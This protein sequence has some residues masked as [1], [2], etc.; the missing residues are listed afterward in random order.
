MDDEEIYDEFG[1]LIGDELDSDVENSRSSQEILGDEKEYPDAKINGHQATQIVVA[2]EEEHEEQE[3]LEEKEENHDDDYDV[4]AGQEASFQSRALVKRRLSINDGEIIYVNPADATLDEQV[5]DPNIQKEMKTTIDEKELPQLTYSRE[6]LIDTINNV[7]ERIRNVA[8]VGSHQSGK[9]RFIDTFIKNTHI[10]PQDLESTKREAKS[11]RYL[12]NYKL[13]IERETTIKTSAITLM[14]Q[15]QRDRSFAIT[16]VDTPGHIDFQDEVVAGLQLCDGA[17]LVIDAVIGFTFRDKKLI[18]EIMKRDLPIIIVLNKIDNLILKLRLPPKDS[19]L[20]MYNILDDIN[21]YVKESLKRFNYSQ[22]IEFLPTL[23]NVIFASADYEISFSLQSFVALYAQTQ[24]HILEDA[25][26]A[27]FLWGEYFLDP[28]TNRIVTDSQQ[29]QLPRTFVSFILDMLYDITSNVIISEPSNKRLPKLLWDHFRVSLPKKEYKKELK[30][31]LRVVF[32]A[33]FRND[34]G[35]VDSVT[36]FILSPSNVTNSS[37]YFTDN[38]NNHNNNNNISKNGSG[39]SSSNNINSN[40]KPSS[41]IGIIPKVIESSDGGTFLCL[42]RLIEE[43]L[44]EGHQIQVI[45]GNTDL[46]ELSRKVLTVQRLYIPGGR[47]N[48]PV[49]SIGPGSVV[50]VEGID[51]SFKKGALIMRESSYTAN[52]LMQY[53]FP[54]YNVNSV[55]KLGMEAVDERQTATLLAS[56][57]KADKAYLSLVVRVEETGEITVIAPGEFYMDCVLHDVRELFADEFQIRVSDPT[58]IFSETCTEMSFTSIPAKTSN[59]SFSISIIAEPV[60]D[61]DLSNAIESGVLHA[62]LSRKEMATILKTQFGWDALAA[63]SVWVFGPKDLIEPDILIDDTFQGETDKQ[64]LMKLKEYISSGFEWAIAEGPLMAETIRNTKFKI[65]EAKFKLDDLASYTPA[66]IIP[67]IQRA[68]YTGFLTAQPRLMEPVYRLDAICFYK[69]IKVVD[70][71][72]KSRRGHIETRDPIEGTALHYIVGYIPVVDSFGFASDVKLYTYR[73]ANT[74]LLFSHWSI[75]PG[76]PFDL[77]CELPRLKPAPVESLSRDFLL[78][79]RHRKGL[80]GEPTLQKYIDSEIY[81]KLKERGLV[82]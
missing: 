6:F 71:L 60:N 61:P 16:L 59:D 75:V 4:V 37:L 74:W 56:L 77:V 79:T 33:I 53:M 66:Q 15:D 7:P 18:D 12:D 78:K 22:A 48:V 17:I 43:G 2:G 24:P 51:S 10:L 26:F 55:L 23:G 39:S 8:V 25:N 28:E 42:V 38:H 34:T 82:A 70:E 36:S 54:N 19:Y 35:F 63:R 41:I 20:K 14:L 72:L 30:D 80:T 49:S 45:S 27:N 13:E 21:A 81:D 29:G 52:Q 9:T 73:N 40:D 47:Y 50:L 65:L 58:T 32:K 64:Q 67:V 68:C 69:N 44:V 1:N 76:D 57:R 5:I 31:L 46:N 62:N 11:L 3:E